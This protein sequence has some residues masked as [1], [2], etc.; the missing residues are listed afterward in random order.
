[1][2][3]APVWNTSRTAPDGLAY[4]ATVTPTAAVIFFRCRMSSF[5]SRYRIIFSEVTLG[6]RFY[7]PISQEYFVKL[8]VTTAAMVTGI[9]D[10]TVPDDFEL[11]D[12]VGID[13]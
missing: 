10:G 9:G 7:D 4:T 2:R 13:H 3:G 8:S 5:P 1:M 11:D 12:V 6:Q